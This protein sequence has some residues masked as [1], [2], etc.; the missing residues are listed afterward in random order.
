M[1]TVNWKVDGMTCSNCALTVQQYLKGEG[2]DNVKV[3]PIDGEVSFDID[4]KSEQHIIKGI[5]SLGY[6][7]QAEEVPGNKKRKR[8]LK[9]HKERFLFCL[10]FTLPLLLHMLNKW[11]HL[12][13]LMNPW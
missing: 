3:N 1:K 2:I 10:V 7:V 8:L 4:G 12:H 9:N 6:S 13:W 5:E 11:W